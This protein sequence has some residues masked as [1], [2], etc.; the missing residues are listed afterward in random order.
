MIKEYEELKQ[1]YLNLFDVDDPVTAFGLM[2]K[3]SAVCE[4]LE[5]QHAKYTRY[6]L[7]AEKQAEA[8][9][10]KV[11]IGNGKS[12]A[13][14]KRFA[15]QDPTVV[16]AWRQYTIAMEKASTINAQARHTL[17]I[18]YDTKRVWELGEKKERYNG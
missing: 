14:G 6:A 1:E 10:A 5:S 8:L 7:E 18:Y 15:E 9:E 16:E 17:R 12:V 3:A 13:E 11:S 4:Y 2:R